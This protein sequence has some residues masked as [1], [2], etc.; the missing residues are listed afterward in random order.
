MSR[1]SF[2]IL[3]VMLGWAT[4]FGQSS[5]KGLTPGRSTRADVERVLGQP[6]KELKRD[7]H[8]IPPATSNRQDFRA[9]PQ[10]LAGGRTDRDGL[11]TG[12][13]DM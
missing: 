6:V 10:G 8:R 5:F 9:V 3:I 2:I 11:P 4:C 13:L 7:A 12:D 1:I